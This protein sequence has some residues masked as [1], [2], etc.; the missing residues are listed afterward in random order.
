MRKYSTD[1][2]INFLRG[3]VLVSSIFAM[4]GCATTPG[5]DQALRD[6]REINAKV[7]SLQ[8]EQREQTKIIESMHSTLRTQAK[9]ATDFGRLQDSV[10]VLG[11]RVEEL[12]ARIAMLGQKMDGARS[13]SGGGVANEA[14]IR[15][16]N[17]RLEKLNERIKDISAKLSRAL[18]EPVEEEGP[19]GSMPA[20]AASAPGQTEIEENAAGWGE[21]MVGASPEAPSEQADMQEPGELYQRAYSAYLSGQ[22]NDAV[23]GF[24]G[25]LK[26]YPNTE[27]SDNA[28]YWLA[29]SYM[30]GDNLEAAA[31][32]FDRMAE[33]FPYSNK[34]PT[35]LLRGAQ[36]SIK[37]GR[38]A[39]AEE[40][41][42]LVIEKYP[43]AHEA[44]TAR[45]KLAEIKR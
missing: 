10:L 20:A 13:T 2:G 19:S 21:P 44:A 22:F 36:I 4:G 25:Y 38:M 23:A 5:V 12:N 45:S 30:G 3:A 35:A 7:D 39:Q 14:E 41:L 9:M 33:T 16:I 34:A 8:N 40:K 6:A 27:L 18:G 29:E 28:I 43:T 17:L 1:H 37:L 24:D 15:V 26:L 31:A 42:K 11:G 32:A